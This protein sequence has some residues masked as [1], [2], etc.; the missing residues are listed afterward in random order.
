MVLLG[1]TSPVQDI[2]VGIVLVARGRHR[3]DRSDAATDGPMTSSRRYP[4]DD[5]PTEPAGAARRDARH[6]RLVRR[7]PCGR[8]RHDRPARRRGRRPRRRQR[9]RQ[10]DADARALGRATR[11]TPARSSSTAS[12]SR[13]PTRATPRRYGIETIYQ[14]LALADNIDA[15]ANMFLGR[16]LT[17]RLGI[18]RRQRDGG[19]DA[20]GDGPPEPE[21]QELQGRP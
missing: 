11:P 2:V 7:R 20:Q 13:S 18:A 17:T 19:G 6:P 12:R 15:A 21:L 14:T 9:R 1:S 10:V 3:H 16:E 4:A 5:R 8:R